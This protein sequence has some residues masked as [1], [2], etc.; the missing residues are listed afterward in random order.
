MQL[1]NNPLTSFPEPPP[2]QEGN[3]EDAHFLNFFPLSLFLFQ[4]KKGER[5]KGLFFQLLPDSCGGREWE[6]KPVKGFLMSSL[7]FFSWLHYIVFL[8]GAVL[9]D[10]VQS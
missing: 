6:G 1:K 3:S 8:R 7:D 4:K 2:P 5:R 10:T 9:S